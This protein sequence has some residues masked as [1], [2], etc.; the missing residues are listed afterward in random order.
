[1]FLFDLL[2][3]LFVFWSFATFFFRRF[4]FYALRLW[5]EV[6]I[7][8]YIDTYFGQTNNFVESFAVTDGR[9]LF[10]ADFDNFAN[11][12]K[13]FDLFDVMTST[14]NRISCVDK[15]WHF[16]ENLLL[17]MYIHKWTFFFRLFWVIFYRIREK[18]YIF[19]VLAFST[20]QRFCCLFWGKSRQYGEKMIPP[21]RFWL[22]CVF[23]I[24]RNS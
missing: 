1:M 6:G 24:F 3:F 4:F 22:A 11:I 12:S 14:L 17:S 19:D 10:L 18:Q 20:F 8:M 7:F 2:L 5:R 9:E 21:L 13:R 15:L 16:F 23:F